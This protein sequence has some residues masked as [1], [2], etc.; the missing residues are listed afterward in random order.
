M[1][2]P[3]S[4]VEKVEAWLM[5]WGDLDEPTANKWIAPEL[6]Q[7]RVKLSP[8]FIGIYP[9]TQEQWRAIARL[10]KVKIDLPS[11]P[12]QFKGDKRPVEQVSWEEAVEFCERLS[13]KTGNYYRL[14]SEAQWEYAC[15]AGTTTSFHF[16]ETMTPELVN[17][18]GNYPY[19]A[20]AVGEFRQ[21][22]TE[23]RTFGVANEFGL[24]D[25]H[26]NVWE[27]CEDI[28]HDC[29]I[30]APIN[31]SAWLTPRNDNEDLRLLRGGS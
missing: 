2:T 7:H 12:S 1:G 26:G 16:G 28:F 21:E 27:W 22:T 9:V 18:D 8:F 31:G 14:P 13:H 20:A 3:A 6:P 19:D 10:P 4:D 11:D 17:Y 30:G 24:C 23:V 15:R 5:K 25:M 29:Y